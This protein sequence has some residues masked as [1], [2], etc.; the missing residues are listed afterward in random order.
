PRMHPDG[1]VVCH[2]LNRNYD[3]T[4]CFVKKIDSVNIILEEPSFYDK[5]CSIKLSSPDTDQVKYDY[6][7][8]DGKLTV[9]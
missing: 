2:I 9:Y 7:I 8:E 3:E 4:I 6:K 1:S 5:P